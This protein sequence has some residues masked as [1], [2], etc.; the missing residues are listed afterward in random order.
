MSK[1]CSARARGSRSSADS[2][3][4]AIMGRCLRRAR[5]PQRSLG[6]RGGRQQAPRILQ[7]L[8]GRLLCRNAS[9]RPRGHL[10]SG[11]VGPG[12]AATQ[13]DR[14]SRWTHRLAI[15][16]WILVHCGS[17]GGGTTHVVPRTTQLR[18][19]MKLEPISSRHG[20]TRLGRTG[21]KDWR[22]KSSHISVSNMPMA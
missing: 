3:P 15:G 14:R 6:H 18:C 16:G 13:S 7:N 8:A 11:Q 1:P 9:Q 5:A 4:T 20:A 21:P 22:D 2:H 17:S 19:W 10:A 12:V